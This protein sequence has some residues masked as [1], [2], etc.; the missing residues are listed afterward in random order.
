M[1]DDWIDAELP[2]CGPC[3]I[4][5]VPGV[6]ARHRVLDAIAEMVHAGD[7]PA[8]V[9]ADFGVSRGFVQRVSTEWPAVPDIEEGKQQ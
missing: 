4:C 9:A 3:L 1:T 8:D 2:K 5:G 7:V 6:D